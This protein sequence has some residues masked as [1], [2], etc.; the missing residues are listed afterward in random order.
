[1][2]CDDLSDDI[3]NIVR[4]SVG[5]GVGYDRIYRGE[6]LAIIKTMISQLRQRNIGPPVFAPVKSLAPKYSRDHD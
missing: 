4:N 1:M 6:I 2:K 3:G 5:G